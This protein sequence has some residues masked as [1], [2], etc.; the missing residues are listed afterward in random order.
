MFIL[1]SSKVLGYRYSAGGGSQAMSAIH[2]CRVQFTG[3]I[4]TVQRFQSKGC[5]EYSVKSTEYRHNYQS[6][7]ELVHKSFNQKVQWFSVLYRVQAIT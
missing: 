6:D 5:T 4:S 1:E 7:I 2:Y 3:S